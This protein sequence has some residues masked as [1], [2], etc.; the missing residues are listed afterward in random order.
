VTLPVLEWR[1]E[2]P[3]HRALLVHGLSST[4]S[5]WWRVAQLVAEQNVQVVAPDL[6]GH[7]GA[8]RTLDY[9]LGDHA[10]DLHALG[11]GW[12]V[13]VGHSFAGG[14]LAL[15]AHTQGFTT[16]LLLLDPVLDIPDD[17][18]EDIIA[19]QLSELDPNADAAAIHA[20]HPSWHIED[21]FHKAIGARITS[22]FVVESCLRQNR[23]WHHLGLLDH[24]QANTVI[25]GA[26][27]AVGSMF[28]PALAADLPSGNVSFRTVTGVGHGIHREAAA[29]VADAIQQL[30]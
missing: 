11:M 18:L 22:P 13:A 4:A 28:P 24:A 8:P 12:D 20:A 10:A 19:G 5:S 2:H 21:A 25:L 23:P 6:R 3:E 29:Y 30:L 9:R 16:S 15:A 26:D 7:G 14:I 1:P 27:P 17:S